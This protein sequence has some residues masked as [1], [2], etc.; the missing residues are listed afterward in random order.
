MKLSKQAKMFFG[1]LGFLIALTTLI[2]NDVYGAMYYYSFFQNV[3]PNLVV[4]MS[5]T[6]EIPNF[7]TLIMFM[8]GYVVLGSVV[9]ILS[10]EMFIRLCDKINWQPKIYSF[11][12]ENKKLE[13]ENEKI[14]HK[15]EA[16]NETVKEEVQ[17][18]KKI[19]AKTVKK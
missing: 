2:G 15:W 9:A 12:I 8:V 19:A 6:A 3:D 16:Q 5:M 17:P 1:F 10:A 7:I 4:Q 13:A 11:L 18:L 14:L